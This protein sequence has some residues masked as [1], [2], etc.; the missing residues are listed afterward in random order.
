MKCS[1]HWEPSCLAGRLDKVQ[2]RDDQTATEQVWHTGPSLLSATGIS[3]NSIP[4]SAMT[5]PLPLTAEGHWMK[6]ENGMQGQG[7]A[8]L[9]GS[10]NGE[11]FHKAGG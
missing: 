5:G 10:L 2:D 3:L 7:W 8:G 11:A 9:P 1:C 6:A 4:T